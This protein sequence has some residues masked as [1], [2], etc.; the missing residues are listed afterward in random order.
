MDSEGDTGGFLV[1]KA[2]GAS[3]PNPGFGTY[4]LEGAQG[5]ASVEEALNQGYRHFDTAEAYGNEKEIGEAMMASNMKRWDLFLTSKV[6]PSN[7]GEGDFRQAVGGSL[8]RLRTD[9]LDLLLLHWPA[10]RKA[11]LPAAVERLNAVKEEGLTKHIGVSNFTSELLEEAWQHTSAPLVVNQVEYHPYLDQGA[12]LKTME[13][14]GMLL[15][16]YCPLAQGRAAGDPVLKGVGEDHGKSA[17]QV[18]LRWLVQRGSVPLP[19]TS[20]PDHGLENLNIFDFQLSAGE[21]EKIHELHEPDGRIIDPD[22]KA[23]D[24]D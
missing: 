1:R 9:Q 3:I 20:K 21:M 2:H 14:R 23:P 24:W 5:R 17:A 19:R 15:T 16:A 10:F 6:S 12:L 13:E 11:E 7:F 18:A 4:K 8:E 22:D